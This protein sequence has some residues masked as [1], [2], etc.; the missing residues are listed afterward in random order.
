MMYTPGAPAAAFM[1]P[2]PQVASSSYGATAPSGGIATP[3]VPYAYTCASSTLPVGTPPMG[4]CQP[5]LS[6]TSTAVSAPA[7]IMAATTARCLPISPGT[8]YSP[9]RMQMLERKVKELE[10]VV[11]QKNAEIQSLQAKLAGKEGEKSNR[12]GD[13]KRSG[14]SAPSSSPQP[15]RRSQNRGS[16]P[17]PDARPMV[18]YSALDQT[19]PVDVRLEEYYNAS[20]SAIPFRRINRGFYR[21]GETIVELKIINHRLMAATEEGW[22]RGKFGNIEKFMA[23]FETIEREKAGLLDE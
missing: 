23:H 20:A 14:R 9:A 16:S 15:A 17:A 1:R 22:N 5:S 10:K 4:G 3:T 7:P 2:P 11:E 21:F 19:D 12:T 18:P 8:D 13:A 6:R